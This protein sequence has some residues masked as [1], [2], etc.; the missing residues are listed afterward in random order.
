MVLLA[1]YNNYVQAIG[2]GEP[3]DS[4]RKYYPINR[5]DPKTRYP[6]SPDLP[7]TLT[8]SMSFPPKERWRV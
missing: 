7:E 6:R 2:G 3:Y 8:G 1:R 5:T 4:A